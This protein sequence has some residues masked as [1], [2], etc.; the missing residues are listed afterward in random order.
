MGQPSGH[1]A[2]HG[3]PLQTAFELALFMDQVRSQLAVH[4]DAMAHESQV[5]VCA[6]AHHMATDGQYF[7]AI[8]HDRLHL[9]P[10]A[11]FIFSEGLAQSRVQVH[12][13]RPLHHARLKGDLR[14]IGNHGPQKREGCAP[15]YRFRQQ[16]LDHI[17]HMGIHQVRIAQYAIAIDH[18]VIR[19]RVRPESTHCSAAGVHADRIVDAL[20]LDIVLGFAAALHGMNAD[21]DQSL[22]LVLRVKLLEVR[23]G[24]SARAS[25]GSPKIDQHHLAP[26]IRQVERLAVEPSSN[27]KSRGPLALQVAQVLFT[28]MVLGAGAERSGQEKRRQDYWCCFE[29]VLEDCRVRETASLGHARRLST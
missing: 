16:L 25:P 5:L 15:R 11:L 14:L 4:K 8:N 17:V 19:E 27:R 6:H 24:T 26:Q 20:G 23:H 29:H 7:L 2:Q 3:L 13:P 1:I 10:G 12:A 22:I 9:Q 28:G 18:V 21:Q